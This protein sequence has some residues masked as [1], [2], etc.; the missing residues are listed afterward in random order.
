[1]RGRARSRRLSRPAP[2]GLP[3]RAEPAE[4]PWRLPSRPALSKVP[5]EAPSPLSSRRCTHQRLQLSHPEPGAVEYAEDAAG[6]TI[7]CTDVTAG[8]GLRRRQHASF[9][10]ERPRWWR[11]RGSQALTGRSLRCRHDHDVVD[12]RVDVDETAA[13]V[14]AVRVEAAAKNAGEWSAAFVLVD[15]RRPKPGARGPAAEIAG[16][17][18]GNQHVA[19]PHGT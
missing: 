14:N 12:L 10:A 4:G 5:F 17:V 19:T 6:I 18:D 8:R 3:V 9:D 1:M 2:P 11:L 15:R 13:R 7:C 16:E